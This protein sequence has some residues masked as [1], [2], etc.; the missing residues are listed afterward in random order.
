[1]SE[2]KKKFG[3]HHG[4][5]MRVLEITPD[6][7]EA[8]DAGY[9]S[10]HQ[11]EMIVQRESIQRRQYFVGAIV[12]AAVAV[13]LM[14][15]SIPEPEDIRLL[16]SLAGL[17]FVVSAALGVVGFGK[18]KQLER[19][20]GN[21]DIATLQGIAVVNISDTT[22][23]LEINGEQLKASPD[24]LRRIKHLEPYV[25]HYLPKSKAI[26]S[27]QPLDEDGNMRDDFATGRLV[28]SSGDEEI[29][30]VEDKPQQSSQRS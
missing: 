7:I 18:Q 16:F 2:K 23:V 1:M 11:R 24:I 25:V 30:Y 26:L 15:L 27:M 6:D 22:S 19:E 17:L 9:I 28:D 29:V 20:L 3:G 21:N 5:L 13:F 14:G 12:V 10:Q 8:N 4:E